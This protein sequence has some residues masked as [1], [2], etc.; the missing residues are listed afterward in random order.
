MTKKSKVITAIVLTAIFITLIASLA[1]A[2]RG[3]GRRYGYGRGRYGHRF[4][5]PR[6]IGR[7]LNYLR[8]HPDQKVRL[9]AKQEKQIEKIW[10]NH[11]LQARTLR[12]KLMDLY[13]DRASDA[14]IRKLEQKLETLQ[15]KF[16]NNVKAVLNKQQK[17]AFESE[18][19]LDYRRYGR[20]RGYGRGYHRGYGRGYHHRGYGRGRR[21]GYGPGNCPGYRGRY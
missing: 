9:T 16:E 4:G 13:H 3:R 8:Y 5:N 11:A 10:R 14:Q 17:K 19:A 7:R 15:K 2:Y 18:A 12:W 20:R 21:Y 1:V 6:F